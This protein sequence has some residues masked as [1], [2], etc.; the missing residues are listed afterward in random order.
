MAG[1]AAKSPWPAGDP[2]PTVIPGTTFCSSACVCAVMEWRRRLAQ[3]MG[4]DKLLGRS[5]CGCVPSVFSTAPSAAAALPAA[6]PPP[7]LNPALLPAVPSPEPGAPQ[8]M[9]P[10]RASWWLDPWWHLGLNAEGAVFAFDAAAAAAAVAA[11]CSCRLCL[12]N[13]LSLRNLACRSRRLCCWSG[14][15]A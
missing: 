6:A 15:A 11:A 10:S 3:P 1:S 7:A 12:M 13:C 9:E 2:V 5:W 8:P 4:P 14:L